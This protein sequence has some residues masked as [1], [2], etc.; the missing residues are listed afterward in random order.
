VV[1][2]GDLQVAGNKAAGSGSVGLGPQ[3]FDVTIQLQRRPRQEVTQ[4]QVEQSA[5]YFVGKWAFEYVGGE[6]PPLSAGTRTGTVA[7][8][9]TNSPNVVT[10]RIDG[11]VAGKPYQEHVSI[12]FD[13]DSRS[14]AFLERRP[15]GIELLHAASWQ[16]PLAITFQSSP[17]SAGNR[18]YQLRRVVQVVS[19]TTFEMTEEFSVD[20]GPYRRLGS[21]QFSRVE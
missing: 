16:S 6:F 1:I 7:F 3:A 20:G 13:P 11:E 5:A 17:V 2:K 19:D 12:V 15:G 10:G 9:K 14:L 8:S 18:T 4:P 21:G